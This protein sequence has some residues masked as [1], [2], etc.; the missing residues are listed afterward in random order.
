MRFVVSLFLLLG[1]VGIDAMP[2]YFNL[3]LLLLSFSVLP[4]QF[5]FNHGTLVFWLLSNPFHV[6]Q[7]GFSRKFVLTEV[8]LSLNGPERPLLIFGTFFFWSFGN[9]L[10][11]SF[12]LCLT[13]C[14]L[15]PDLVNEFLFL[16]GPFRW[17]LFGNLSE[18]L[19]PGFTTNLDLWMGLGFML[20]TAWG[21]GER[22]RDHC[23]RYHGES[24]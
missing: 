20:V 16:L 10:C 1:R 24:R 19:L 6:F 17:W 21:F 15:T 7:Q 13:S 2:R 11:Q 4:C 8:L 18:A 9:L 12:P 5:I 23:S 22:L 3:L 14:R